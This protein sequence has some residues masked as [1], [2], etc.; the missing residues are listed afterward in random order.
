MKRLTVLL[1][2]PLLLQSQGHGPPPVRTVCEV[3]QNVDQ[4]RGKAV[5]L[6]GV[7]DEG[8]NGLALL[9]SDC[10]GTLVVSGHAWPKAVKLQ[11]GSGEVAYALKSR[12]KGTVWA[13]L[14]GRL[15]AL[16]SYENPYGL[17]IL[18]DGHV[19]VYAVELNVETVRDIEMR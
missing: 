16:Q 14:T 17:P 3:L 18:A 8:P 9:G 13:T 1:F 6:R 12:G 2:I 11:G 15:Q 7:I 19:W 10:E 4:Y 5:A